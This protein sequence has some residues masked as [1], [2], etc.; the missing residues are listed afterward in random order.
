MRRILFVVPDLNVGGVQRSLVTL[1]N[2]A[3]FNQL[4][5]TLLTFREGGGLYAQLPDQV[6]VKVDR[7]IGKAEKLRAAVSKALRQ[8]RLD[9]LFDFAKKVY[10]RSGKM[11]VQANGEEEY[12]V[13]VAYSDGLATWYVAQNVQA[14]QK[15]AFVHTDFSRAGYNALQEQ[16]V[17]GSFEQIIFPSQAARQ[18][19]LTALPK[20]KER[21]IVLP[22]AVD[23]HQVRKLAKESIPRFEA[24]AVKLVTVGRLSHEKGIE[25][26]PPLLR[27][28]KDAGQR[29]IWYVVG[30][31]PE[32]NNILRQ[33][34]KLGVEKELILTGQLEN[35]YPYMREC[36]VYVQPSEYEGYC[37]ALAEARLLCR[38]VVACDFAGAR[39]QIE[40]GVTGFITGVTIEDLFPP[41]LT[42]V[43]QPQKRMEFQKALAQH[44]DAGEAV[45]QAHLWWE[46]LSNE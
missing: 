34:R 40:S 25:K 13:A 39:E 29:V 16:E 3:P 38:P 45:L 20:W 43:T 2:E 44:Y 46:S 37:I 12:D 33:A 35:P 22:N 42:L 21:T 26:I 36:D 19:F 8:C 4:D 5:I 24:G 30:D 15:I 10:H 7:Q 11:M 28:L 14:A 27:R 17:Y 23:I 31:G 1:L 32:R 41:L 9:S 6:H 18:S